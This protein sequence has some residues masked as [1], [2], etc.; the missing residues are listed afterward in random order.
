MKRR[1]EKE[2]I[3]LAEHLGVEPEFLQECV[4]QGV[5][6]V[7]ELKGDPRA[8]SAARLAR[9]QRLRRL[10]DALELDVFAGSLIVDLL[11]QMDDLRRELNSAK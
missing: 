8:L 1:S 9:L 3:L 6:I 5:L 7:E 4:R 2:I 10:C 11:E